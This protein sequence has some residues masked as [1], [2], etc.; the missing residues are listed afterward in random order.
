MGMQGWDRVE[1]GGAG[2]L[3]NGQNRG[4]GILPCITGQ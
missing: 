2:L 1:G 4:C 3:V